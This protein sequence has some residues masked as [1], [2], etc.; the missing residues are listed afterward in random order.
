[1]LY[2]ST[3]ESIDQHMACKPY[4][5][6]SH[7]VQ[8]SAYM[9]GI[10]QCWKYTGLLCSWARQAASS[11]S[12]GA[13]PSPLHCQHRCS[14]C[15]PA[16]VTQVVPPSHSS[17]VTHHMTVTDMAL[18]CPVVAFANAHSLIELSGVNGRLQWHVGSTCYVH[19]AS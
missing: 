12:L 10:E 9:F 2:L 13:H 4:L 14:T 16:P 3:S 18:L 8:C 15:S 5:V 11:S 17:A 7:L 6:L 1:M 19:V